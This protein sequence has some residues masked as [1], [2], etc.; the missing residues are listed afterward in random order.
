MT[1]SFI[2]Q[3]R[4]K[5]ESGPYRAT[6]R[7]YSLPLGN[8]PITLLGEPGR[9]FS[10]RREE[11]ALVVEPNEPLP[12][13]CTIR[14]AALFAHEDGFPDVNTVMGRLVFPHGS[15]HG[16]RYAAFTRD[17][18]RKLRELL[19]PVEAAP[20]DDAPS[21]AARWRNFAVIAQRL[22]AAADIPW[23]GLS[24]DTIEKL[25]RFVPFVEPLE[26]CLLH[27][28]VQWTHDRGHYVV[29]IGSFRGRSISMLALGLSGAGSRAPII[30]IDPHADD[31]QNP[32]HVRLALAQLGEEQRLVQFA[33]TSD[34]AWRM[35]RPESASFIFIDG[36]HA[37]EQVVADF[38]NYRDLL[39]PGG[40]MVFHDYG[41]GNHNGLPEAAPE[42]R[43]AIDEHVMPARAFR[44]LLLAHTQIALVKN[45]EDR[46]TR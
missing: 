11:G 25:V 44:P 14:P 13:R 27:A 21:T 3:P 32:A 20:E 38:N 4:T 5:G 15:T 18:R 9:W 8:K 10:V 33:C 37:Y 28:L 22:C 31:P 35:L 39:A 1:T 36:N 16:Q 24:E 26:G 40:C 29:E 7:R 30:S 34:E 2:E 46:T 45:R 17:P 6:E 41:Y 42:V 19:L 12:K 23:K 43:P